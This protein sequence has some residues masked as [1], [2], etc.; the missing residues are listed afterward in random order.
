MLTTCPRGVMDNTQDS[1]SCAGGSIPSEGAK[2]RGRSKSMDLPLFFKK[3]YQNKKAVPYIINNNCSTMFVR[4]IG[5][6]TRSSTTT[7]YKASYD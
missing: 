5:N 4:G 6:E 2:K 7:N 1:G 3:F